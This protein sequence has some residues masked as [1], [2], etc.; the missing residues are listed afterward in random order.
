[1]AAHDGEGGRDT[2]R[3]Y[4]RLAGLQ[5]DDPSREIEGADDLAA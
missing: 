3:G 4:E 2:V 5:G 1:M